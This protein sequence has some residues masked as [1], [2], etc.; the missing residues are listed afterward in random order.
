MTTKKKANPEMTKIMKAILD[1]LDELGFGEKYGHEYCGYVMLCLGATIV[2]DH[3]CPCRVQ[4]IF[5]NEIM[6][7]ISKGAKPINLN[8]TKKRSK[9]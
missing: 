3:S 6:P 5:E 7:N 2:S 1:Q 9:K 4:E 8:T